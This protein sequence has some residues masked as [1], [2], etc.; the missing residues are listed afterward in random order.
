LSWKIAARMPL[1]PERHKEDVMP[2][3]AWMPC[4][5]TLLALA[6]IAG[7]ASDPMVLT[8]K[9]KYAE[10]QQASLTKQNQQLQDRVVTLERDNQSEKILSA[11][12]QQQ[13]QNANEQL[14]ALR[15]D[16]RLLLAKLTQARADKEGSDRQIQVMTASLQRQGGVTL[17]PN[18]SILQTLPTVN[19][20]GVHVR[21]DGSVIRVEME[22]AVLFEPGTDRLRPSAVNVITEA[23]NAIARLYPYQMIGIESHTDNDPVAGSQWRNNHALSTDRAKQVY[24]VLVSRTPLQG[25]QLFVVGRGSTNPIVSNGSAE[26]KQRNR[27]VELVIYPDRKS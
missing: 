19:A 4:L 12:A 9:L 20:E 25:E 2:R 15:V 3:I 5:G 26:G 11:Q 21:S 23:A 24:E 13:A 14:N 22:A 16:N 27:R 18:N 8:G 6:T 10:M 17:S 7:C 1:L